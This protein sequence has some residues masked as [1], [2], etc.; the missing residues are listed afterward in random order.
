MQ[1][2]SSRSILLNGKETKI[3]SLTQLCKKNNNNKTGGEEGVI[4]KE[5]T[6]NFSYCFRQQ[7]IRVPFTLLS[8]KTV[9][10]ESIN[11]SLPYPFFLSQASILTANI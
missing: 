10:L 3:I 4:C 9:F 7:P 8:F 2:I 5:L 6:C 1:Q 11:V